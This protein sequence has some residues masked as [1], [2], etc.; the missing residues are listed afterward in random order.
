MD[1]IIVIKLGGSVITNKKTTGKLRSKV[2]S[3][4]G[5]Q[6]LGLVKLGHKII[7][8]HGAGGNIHKL[9]K[10]YNL[11]NGAQ[12][13]QQIIGALEIQNE[14]SILQ[15]KVSGILQSQALP[16]FPLQTSSLFEFKNRNL[17]LLNRGLID[18][19]LDH[20]AIPLLTGS[21]VPDDHKKWSILSGDNLAIFLAKL[22]HSKQIY[23]LTDVDGFLV[24][25]PELMRLV[26][27]P[28]LSASELQQQ[29][30]AYKNY[31]AQDATGEMIG[32]LTVVL[33]KPKHTEIIIRNGLKT[34]SLFKRQ[35]GTVIK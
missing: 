31:Q 6:I 34:H 19:I 16:I 20:K 10:K 11:Q 27:V 24:Q 29:I 13:R 35:D 22:Y 4:L 17:K 2:I 8:I 1:S 33:Q 12:S 26:V 21:M 14:I 3:E 23:F 25:D 5:E 28:K 7:L 18:K 9:A 32:K 15:S 30:A